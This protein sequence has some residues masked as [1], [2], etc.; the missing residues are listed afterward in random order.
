MKT[1]TLGPSKKPESALIQGL[2]R[3]FHLSVQELGSLLDA[4]LENGITFLD[5]SDI[6]SDGYCEEL[7]G[8]VF[9]QRPELRSKFSLQ[10]KCGI[11]RS[12]KGFSFYDFSKE[13]ILKAADASLK[14][15][16][17]EQIDY[18]LLHRPDALFEPEEIASAFDKLAESGKV[19]SFGV[20]NFNSMQ[21]K[22]LKKH[23]RQ[24]IEVNQLQYTVAHSCMIDS[25][26]CTNRVETQSF[27]HDIGIL[28]YCRLHDCTIQAWSPFRANKSEVTGE[29]I[30]GKMSS[31]PF[32]G[33]DEFPS[34]N[35]SLNAYAKEFGVSPAAIVV[36]WILRHP[37]NM[38]IV[39]GSS[40]P[41]R[42]ADACRGV[43]VNLSRENWY[44]IYI[45]AGNIIP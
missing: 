44:D 21:L 14:R 22:L 45:A 1:I 11:R 5:T 24:P 13:H 32:L 2:M 3:T 8:K 23:V 30:E 39:L 29:I 27:D 42:I 16:Q 25:A 34:L 26:L 10:T 36:A 7:L 19:R 17:T 28:D 9:A 43:Q 20:S 33:S 12:S 18:Y 41:E 15:L 38:Q 6:Y 40:K 31:R 4:D 35:A 37:A